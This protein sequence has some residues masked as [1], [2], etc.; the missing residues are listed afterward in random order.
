MPRLKISDP[1]FKDIFFLTQML[2][3][4]KNPTMLYNFYDKVYKNNPDD[5]NLTEEEK[6]EVDL[7]PS[8]PDYKLLEAIEEIE[9]QLKVLLHAYDLGFNEVIDGFMKKLNDD[10]DEED[11][12]NNDDGNLAE[13]L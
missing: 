13:N 7:V 6:K 8:L 3:W 2:C 12:E 5:H 4:L 11:I 1:G 9:K 10:L